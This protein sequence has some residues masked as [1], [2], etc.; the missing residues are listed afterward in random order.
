MN[1]YYFVNKWPIQNVSAR[2][3]KTLSLLE[4]LLNVGHQVSLFSTDSA[5]ISTDDDLERMPLDKIF[6]NPRKAGP[7]W[8]SA[9]KKP[10]L[11]IFNSFE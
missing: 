9:A 5:P 10:D 7:A 8:T 6:V 4:T 3:D 1:V 2:A 11:A